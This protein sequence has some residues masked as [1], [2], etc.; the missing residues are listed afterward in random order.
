MVRRTRE[1]W[2]ALF[3]AH[4]QSGLSQRQFCK[5][6]RVCPRYFSLRRRQLTS[7]GGVA[8]FVRVQRPGPTAASSA[9][10]WQLQVGEVKLRVLNAPVEQLLSLIKGLS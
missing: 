3:A 9:V 1:Q 8:P 5:E 2:L 7:A 4:R 10:E 6:Q